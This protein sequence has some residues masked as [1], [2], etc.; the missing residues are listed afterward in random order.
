M[1][2]IVAPPDIDAVFAELTPK[3]RTVVQYWNGSAQA[4]WEE[5]EKTYKG[6]FQKPFVREIV[7]D[8][9]IVRAIRLYCEMGDP[10]VLSNKEAQQFWS[11]VVLDDEQRMGDRLKASELLGKSH[12]MFVEKVEL[13]ADADLAKRIALAND[14]LKEID[15][16]V[17][18]SPKE[19]EG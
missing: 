12:K 17:E 4:T 10:G 9:R 2:E 18:D 13:T 3:E 14:R 8:I 15:V 6:E 11:K 7:N 16:V 19:L 1:N 5:L